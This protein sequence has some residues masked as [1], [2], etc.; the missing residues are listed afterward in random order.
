MAMFGY[1][2]AWM[3]ALVS[4]VVLS[5]MGLR[6]A[7]ARQEQREL[8][9]FILLLQRNLP[10]G[11]LTTREI[12][13]ACKST[14]PRRTPKEMIQE[15]EWAATHIR[16]NGSVRKDGAKKSWLDFNPSQELA[17]RTGQ[18]Y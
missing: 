11:T 17:Q 13:E 16:L 3:G 9:Q 6:L 7:W 1:L 4:L 5:Y 14:F 2:L 10:P 12:Q 8:A 15:A 18:H